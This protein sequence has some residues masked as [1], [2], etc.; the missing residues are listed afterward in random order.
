MDSSYGLFVKSLWQLL[1]LYFL[2]TISFQSDRIQR[3]P[4]PWLVT[5]RERPRSGTVMMDRAGCRA[6]YLC[7]AR[8]FV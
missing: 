8:C 7:P 6:C 5:L 4:V 1:S 3:M 2:E